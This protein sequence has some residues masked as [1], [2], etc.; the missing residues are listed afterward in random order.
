MTDRMPGNDVAEW[1]ARLQRSFQALHERNLRPSAEASKACGRFIENR[2]QRE[3]QAGRERGRYVA[4]NSN[5]PSK[6]GG[7]AGQAKR[8]FD[9]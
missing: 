8:A 3:L 5:G 2:G 4:G 6:A 9:E 1:L 7:D